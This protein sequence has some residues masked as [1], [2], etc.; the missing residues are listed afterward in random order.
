M[1]TYDPESLLYSCEDGGDSLSDEEEDSS[2]V[3]ES[4]MSWFLASSHAGLDWFPRAMVSVSAICE[5]LISCDCIGYGCHVHSW[6]SVFFWLFE[7]WWMIDCLFRMCVPVP[8]N[9]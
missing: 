8:C 9:L 6:S 3:V 1:C 2:A 5:G 4:S 7:R